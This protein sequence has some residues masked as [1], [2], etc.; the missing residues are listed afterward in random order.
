M[1]SGGSRADRKQRTRDSLLLAGRA[2]FAQRP[3]ES[4]SIDD[5]V[6]AAKVAKGSFYNHFEDRDALAR[7]VAGEI[8]ALLN[9]RVKR[10]ND[11]VTDPALRVA[12]GLA[13]FFRFA[14]EEPEGAM[15]LAKIHG[16][17]SAPAASHNAPVVDDL[18]RGIAT[19]R[20]RIPTLEAGLMLIVSVGM[21]GLMRIV[22]EPGEAVA[23]SITQQL[24]MLTLRGLGVTD[25]EA[26]QYASQTADAVVRSGGLLNQSCALQPVV[27]ATRA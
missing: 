26:T 22:R 19:G 10:L 17:D 2:L 20:F 1:A 4:V 27:D 21:A 15:A 16:P 25:A 9:D 11:D 7:T 6:V 3:V 5:L 12:R 18:A 13:T 14:V 23:I 24:V 8:R